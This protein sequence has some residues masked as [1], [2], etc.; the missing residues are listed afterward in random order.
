MAM[1]IL[2]K[3]SSQVMPILQ[4]LE[5]ITTAYTNQV[6]YMFYPKTK[7]PFILRIFSMVNLEIFYKI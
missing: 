2:F 4:C 3:D 5:V 6:E 7:T 1:K